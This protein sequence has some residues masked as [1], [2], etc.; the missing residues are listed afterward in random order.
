MDCMDGFKKI[1]DNSINLILTD[2]PFAIEFGAKKTQYNR[3]EGN[4]LKGYNEIKKEDYLKFCRKWLKEF[5]RVLKKNGCVFV[6]SG[7]SNLKDIMIAADEANFTTINHLIW[8]YQFGVFTKKKF[9]TSHYHILFLVRNEKDY[10]FNKIEHYPEDVFEIKREYWTGKE[11]TPTKLPLE[12]VKKLIK[13]GSNE[14]DLVLDC[15]MGSGTTA[16]GAKI[17]NRNYLGFEIVKEYFNFCNKRLALNKSLLESL[18]EELEDTKETKT[19]E[20]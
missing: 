14:G 6:V 12:L 18:P 20:I 15:F 19:L 13:Y 2:P 11:K 4:V 10:I 8:K 1:D 5:Y 3:K 7:W 9:V 17:L 16:V